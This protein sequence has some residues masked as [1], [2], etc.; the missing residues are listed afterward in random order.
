[1]LMLATEE[2]DRSK[3]T[4]N[5]QEGRTGQ[6]QVSG[7][8]AVHV[9]PYV[10]NHT[11]THTRTH[12]DLNVS[13]PGSAPDDSTRLC[14]DRCRTRSRTRLGGAAA[15]AAVGGGCGAVLP[16]PGRETHFVCRQSLG[17]A[18]E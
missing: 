8:R 1:M 15:E 6:E 11:T 4:R 2:R 18:G 9:C 13:P 7:L 10:H 12:A 16:F 3:S 14:P 17:L 5:Q